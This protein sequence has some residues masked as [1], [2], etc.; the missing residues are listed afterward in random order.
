MRSIAPLCRGMRDQEFFVFHDRVVIHF[1]GVDAVC[2]LEFLVGVGISG[3]T[4]RD[5]NGSR[6]SRSAVKI[7][8]PGLRG[9]GPVSLGRPQCVL[10]DGEGVNSGSGPGVETGGGEGRTR[11]IHAGSGYEAFGGVD[12]GVGTGFSTGM[13]LGTCPGVGV[14][15]STGMALRTSGCQ[16]C[17]CWPK[18]MPADP[19]R[20]TPILTRITQACSWRKPHS[21]YLP[22]GKYQARQL[23]NG[24]SRFRP[25]ARR[26]ADRDIASRCG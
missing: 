16:N 12:C 22:P 26:P 4:R 13:A 14:G 11:C 17:C 7:A 24:S 21:R 23:R 19:R 18:I 20:M 1:P 9:A 10:A 5:S 2:D 15:F 3:W 8:G 6:R 25:R